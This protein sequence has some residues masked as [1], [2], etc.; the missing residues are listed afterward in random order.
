MTDPREPLG[1]LV[2]D[3]R[4]ACEAE[5]AALEG[6]QRFNLEPWERRSYEQQETDMRIGAAVAAAERKRIAAAAAGLTRRIPVSAADTERLREIADEDEAA[7]A[8]IEL[9]LDLT[10]VWARSDEEV[11][12]VTAARDALKLFSSEEGADH[13]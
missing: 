8:A 12:I 4:L 9:A 1:R 3:T 6:R 7:K 13:G 5:R 2:H 11:R 10:G